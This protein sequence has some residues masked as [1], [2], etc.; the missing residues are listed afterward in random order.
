MNPSQSWTHF[1]HHGISQDTRFLKVPFG[2]FD[3]GER[4]EY[5]QCWMAWGYGLIFFVL[6]LDKSFALN[7]NH[8]YNMRKW[9]CNELS[10]INVS[11]DVSLRSS[12]RSSRTQH[13][14][15]PLLVLSNMILPHSLISLRA[16]DV[17]QRK[18][19]HWH[20]GTHQTFIIYWYN[21][22]DF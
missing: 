9:L 17:M 14:R 19:C 15:A 12:Q 4:R 13:L 1:I 2:N 6:V 20:N 22:M 16:K 11:C 3:L 8:F 21:E 7:V 10:G 18:L 5:H